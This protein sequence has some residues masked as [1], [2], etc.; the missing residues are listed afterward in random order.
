MIEDIRD[1]QEADIRGR[2]V[3]IRAD[4]N[5]PM[6]DGMP[7]DTTRIE[8]FAP[9]V[10]D[11]VQ[12]GA[13]VVIM[14]HLGRPE[15]EPNPHF[16]T[17]P[18]AD[19]LACA[20]NRDVTFA[21]DCVGPEAERA[22][23]NL[24]PGKV[25]LLENLR[26]HKGETGNS[27]NFAVRLSVNGEVYVNDAFSCAHRRHA[28]TDAIADILPAYAG[29]SLLAEVEALEQALRAPDRP[30]VAVVGGAKVST[31]IAVLKNLVQKLDAV[32]VG[33]GMANTFLFAAGAPMGKSLHEKDQVD[34]VREIQELAAKSD[35]KIILPSDIVVADDFKAGARSQVICS[36]A[37]PDDA[38]ILD[39]GPAS[40][41]VFAQVLSDART[42]LWNGPL[43]AFEIPPFDRA[44]VNLARSA[45]RLTSDGQLTTI[46]GGG[47]TVAA[48]NAA[49]VT[50][51]FTYVSTA[52]GAFLE[53]L[54]G[55]TLPGIAALMQAAKVA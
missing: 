51:D 3:L 11:L 1:I 23:A 54:E 31:K 25:V 4:L 2:T 47:D 30:V 48:L 55:R 52:G 35:C 14:T 16:S 27:R 22:T 36:D 29:P 37:C 5:V 19:A 26:F 24:A 41:L 53:W 17:R 7:A 6:K 38:M 40:L 9:T 44:T 12:R 42:V 34:T 46:A 18:I 39:A 20:L 10:E 8:R 33:G 50:N 49:G 45:A 21:A 13:A 15:G 43:G 28:S 32:I